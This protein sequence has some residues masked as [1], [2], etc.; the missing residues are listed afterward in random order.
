MYYVWHEC[1]SFFKSVI[2]HMHHVIC[3]VVITVSFSLSTY[4]IIENS[5]PV[6]PVLVLSSPSTFGVTIEI[7]NNDNTASGKQSVIL[8]NVSVM[9]YRRR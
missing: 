9:L 8:I 1:I 5:G 4:S 6:Q 2:L 3:Y 7:V